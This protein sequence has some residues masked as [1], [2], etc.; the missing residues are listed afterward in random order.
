MALVMVQGHVCDT[1]LS[2]AA[3]ATPLYQW[4]WLFHGTTAPGFLFASGFVAGLPRAPLSLRAAIRRARRLLFVL[5]VGYFLQLPY[6]SLWKTLEASPAQMSAA[7]ACNALQVIA[8]TQL[9]VLVIQVLARRRWVGVASVLFVVVLVAGPFVWTSGLAQRV[10]PGWGAYLDRSSGSVFP[11]FPF[12]SFV[13]AGAVAGAFIG[14][15]EPGARHRAMVRS[16]LVCLAAGAAMT[17]L[18]NQF[19]DFWGV[20]PAYV[21]LRL[22]A[23]LLLMRTVE[24]LCTPQGRLTQALAVLG[25]ETLLV[26]VVHLLALYGGVLGQGPLAPWT[27]RLGFP[28]AFL[29]LGLMVPTLLAA[30]AAWRRSKAR[31][32]HVAELALAFVTVAVVWDFVTRPW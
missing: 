19:V 17:P 18:L 20:S 25:H 6:F 2:K 23:L 22:G 29:V 4:Q 5:G 9:L 11:V 32:P 28:G 3:V 30:A 21:L 14:H 10:A 12:A 16:G 24:G 8:A 1:L 27:G 13:L 31:F 7:F 15:L 26:Y